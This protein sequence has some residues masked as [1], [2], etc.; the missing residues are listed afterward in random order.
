MKINIINTKAIHPE[1]FRIDPSFHLSEAIVLR[2]ALE[3]VP[4]GNIAIKD[5]TEKVFLGNIFSRIFVK[6]KEHGVPYLAASDTVLADHNTGRFI[7]NKQA[8]ELSYL[9]LKKDWIL[10]T[11][12]GTIGNV[13]YTNST[14]EN[15]LAT[16]DLIRVIPNDNIIKKGCLY[17]YLS[18][19]YGYNQLTQSRFGGVVKHINADHVNNITVPQFP[20]SF[21]KEVDDLILESSRLREEA[22]GFLNKAVSYFE[23]KY[24]IKGE[25]TQF[26]IKK[27]SDLNFSV[28]AYNNNLEVD[29][30]TNSYISNALKLR[31]I[32]SKIFA[33]PLF[34]HIYLSKDNGFPFMTGSELTRFNMRYYRW[35]S[36]KGVKDIQDYVVNTGTLLLYKSGTTDGGILGN[37]FIADET[38]N[39]CCLSDH[40]IRIVFND[41]NL[42]YWTFAFLKSPGGVKLLQRL[43]TGTMIPFITPERISELYIPEPDEYKDT[44]VDYV[45]K[46]VKFS[47]KAKTLE[48][49]AISMVEQE[50]EKWN[51]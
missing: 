17:A 4:Y 46:F 13:T 45:D 51:K 11:C 36:P 10:I 29:K 33:P 44:I 15:H 40:V 43:A 5:V 37:V 39:G 21:Q 20:D 6:D 14:F 31:D 49:L 35:L 32:T 7:A 48:N 26:F 18:S 9:V 50:I 1:S 30:F 34:K 28:A 47:S 8:K 25:I 12:S 23:S 38:L 19:K 16:H 24:P 2:K 22:S 27:I 41:N 3:K 42:A